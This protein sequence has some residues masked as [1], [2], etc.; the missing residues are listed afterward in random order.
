MQRKM[1]LLAFAG[2]CGAFGA[3][4]EASESSAAADLC[5]RS[6]KAR[7]PNPADTV[8]N[9]CRRENIVPTPRPVFLSSSPNLTPSQ[10]TEIPQMQKDS[11]ILPRGPHPLLI[12]Y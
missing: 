4:G 5:N 3:S 11:G 8:F 1:I 7:Y 9:V 2:K 12:C 6:A 10:Q